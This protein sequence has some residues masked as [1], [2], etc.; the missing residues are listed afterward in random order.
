MITN[1]I[2][3][4]GETLGMKN[5]FD[6]SLAVNFVSNCYNRFHPSGIFSLLKRQVGVLVRYY[7]TKSEKLP[8]I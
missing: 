4:D 1:S 6:A 5:L 8:P 3:F 2:R 7:C